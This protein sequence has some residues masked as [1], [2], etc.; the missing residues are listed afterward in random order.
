LIREISDPF[1]T[2]KIPA[3]GRTVA[4]DSTAIIP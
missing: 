1:L 2:T 4:G 3:S